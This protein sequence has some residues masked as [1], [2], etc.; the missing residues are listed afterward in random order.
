MAKGNTA[1]W[2]SLLTELGRFRNILLALVAIV[3]LFAAGIWEAQLV[4]STDDLYWKSPHVWNG[5]V[6][7]IGFACL[8]A[9][10]IIIF[11]EASSRQ[12]QENAALS[13]LERE[14]Q[15]A[16]EL[17]EEL[18]R[19]VFRAVYCRETPASLVD[20][21]IDQVLSCNVVRTYHRSDYK[22]L[23]L[24]VAADENKDKRYVCL[25]IHGEYVVK[26][27]SRDTITVPIGIGFPT[28]GPMNLKKYAKITSV[29]IGGIELN[30]HEIREGDFAAEDDSDKIR[31]MWKRKL[32]AGNQL[33]V[34]YTAQLVKERSD[35][36][37][38]TSLFPSTG[39]ELSLTVEVDDLEF[40]ARSLSSKDVERLIGT[41]AS[42]EMNKWRL[43]GP[44]LP[45]QSIIVW[46]RPKT[47][48]E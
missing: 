31:F 35:N 45:H 11:V 3:L 10:L 21:V 4:D 25:Q 7:E 42:N 18:G 1:F 32:A 16:S 9:L 29:K 13:F 30:E 46:W 17:R 44:I 33:E 5:V 36:E 14:R 26:N 22:L 38:W 27:I 8:I 2:S 39:M 24:D 40:D 43:N 41:R 12:R 6:R 37:V 47:G 48:V 28:P 15:R 20:G 19:D 23:E 34:M